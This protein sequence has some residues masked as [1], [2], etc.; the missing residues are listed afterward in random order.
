MDPFLQ[1]LAEQV[2]LNLKDLQPEKPAPLKESLEERMMEAQA[3]LNY[4]LYRGKK[5]FYKMTCLQ[6]KQS[7]RYDYHYLGIKLCSIECMAQA[8]EDRG[9]KWT[10]DKPLTERWGFVAAPAVIPAPVLALAQK[11]LGEVDED[12]ENES[13]S[14]S[15]SVEPPSEEDSS[16]EHHLSELDS[17]LEDF[18]L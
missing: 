3:T 16:V 4:F 5:T 6:C 13:D 10:P 14:L 17:I 15:D 7:F 9:L 1:S 18:D 8:L 11:L 12:P 2:G